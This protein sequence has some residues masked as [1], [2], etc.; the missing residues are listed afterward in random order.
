MAAKK[1][2]KTKTIRMPK[3][4]DIVRARD[5][6]RAPITSVIPDNTYPSELIGS[7]REHAA[8]LWDA[9]RILRAT[10]LESDDKLASIADARAFCMDALAGALRESIDNLAHKVNEL[11]TEGT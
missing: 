5:I 3:K 6:A 7:W 8:K 2:A 9:A 11:I 4:G 1:K 10:P